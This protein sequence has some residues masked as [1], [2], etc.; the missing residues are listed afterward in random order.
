MLGRVAKSPNEPSCHKAILCA[1]V[2]RAN[3]TM[4]GDSRL[5]SGVDPPNIDALNLFAVLFYPPGCFRMWFQYPQ[6]SWSANP[7]ANTV[8]RRVACLAH[9]RPR[10]GPRVASGGGRSCGSNYVRL[11]A[12][13]RTAAVNAAPEALCNTLRCI[14]PE[15]SDDHSARQDGDKPRNAIV[16]VAPESR[17]RAVRCSRMLT[18]QHDCWHR[19]PIFQPA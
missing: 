10:G 9:L 13:L 19:R 3:S 14:G 11:P 12:D 4:T 7:R 18:R 17:H 5:G 15:E 16:P 2:S 8:S 1:G 6:S